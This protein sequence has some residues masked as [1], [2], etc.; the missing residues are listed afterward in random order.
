MISETGLCHHQQGTSLFNRELGICGTIL[1]K[2]ILQNRM[3]TNS[4]SLGEA[5][6]AP[7]LHVVMKFLG[8]MSDCSSSTWG[9]F[10]RIKEITDWSISVLSVLP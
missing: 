5:P 2:L 1:L 8:Q 3:D 9:Q 6:A 7:S 4:I 10:I